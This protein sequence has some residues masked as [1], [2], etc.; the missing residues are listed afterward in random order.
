MMVPMFNVGF[1][2]M[3]ASIKVFKATDV[4]KQQ[5]PDKELHE[6]MLAKR[7]F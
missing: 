3:A 4:S 7:R 1:V 6:F 2:L 5:Q